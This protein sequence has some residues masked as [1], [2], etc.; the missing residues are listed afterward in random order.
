M[1][2][3]LQL[4]ASCWVIAPQKEIMLFSRL[5]QVKGSRSSS[6]SCKCLGD[7]IHSRSLAE[8]AICMHDHAASA[9]AAQAALLLLHSGNQICS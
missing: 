8:G 5:Q 4:Q 2:G 1:L 6:S 3:A 9:S 7:I